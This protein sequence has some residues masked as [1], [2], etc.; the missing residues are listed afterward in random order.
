MDDQGKPIELPHVAIVIPCF[1]QAKYLPDAIE[2]CLKQSYQNCSIWVVNDGS[3]DNT[4]EVARSY[5]EKV[6][7]LEQPNSGVNAARNTGILASEGEFVAFLDA[8]DVMLPT[9]LEVRMQPLLDNERVGSVSGWYR[10]VDENLKPLPDDQQLWAVPR[11]SDRNVFLKEMWSSTCGYIVRRRAFELCG[12]FDPLITIAE[13]WDF[14]LRLVR[15]FDH[16][17]LPVRLADYRQLSTSASRN[18]TLMYD[19][20]RQVIRK[21]R[22]YAPNKLAYTFIGFSAL[23]TQCS[24]SIFGKILRGESR[25]NRKHYL[26]RLFRTRPSSVIMFLLWVARGAINK[27]LKLLKLKKPP[28]RSPVSVDS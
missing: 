12:L 7:L 17:Y 3:A 5:G 4:S 10:L 19:C 27:T 2:S 11:V 22:A 14:Q 21:N 8:D 18:Y 16:V 6:R 28:S 25:E 24:G 23:L 26:L 9:C 20:I 13:D 1:N 15:K